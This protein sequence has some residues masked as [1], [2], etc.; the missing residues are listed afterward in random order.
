MKRILTLLT[1]TFVLTI[2][3]CT[4]KEPEA[5]VKVPEPVD[6]FLNHVYVVVDSVTYSDI[7]N[8]RFII[9]EFADFIQT[10]SSTD[11]NETWTGTYLS[12]EKTYLE[13]LNAAQ[14]D[15]SNASFCGLGFCTEQ[16][17][18]I[19]NLKLLMQDKIDCKVDVVLRKRKAADTVFP[20]FKQIVCDKYRQNYV[21]DSWIIEYDKDYLKNMM[22]DASDDYHGIT[23]KHYN[24]RY[25]DDSRYLKDVIGVTLALDKKNYDALIDKL[26]IF[27]YSVVQDGVK[28]LCKGEGIEYEIVPAALGQ[29]G[30]QKVKFSLLRPKE[31]EKL[32]TFGS[33]SKLIFYDDLVAEWFF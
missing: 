15:N 33:D 13:I 19:D 23:R 25:F 20:W 5:K 17:G 28:A 12:G 4:E 3:A 8:S 6:V 29:I 16:E 7:A 31:G 21:M 30:I 2:V 1:V 10:T 27:G 11:D 14:R 26:K 22:P 9:N 24:K 32:Y 18:D